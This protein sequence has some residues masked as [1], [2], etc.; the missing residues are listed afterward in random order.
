M[1]FSDNKIKEEF[2]SNG[3]AAIYS[4]FN[5]DKIQEIKNAIDRYIID[6][7]PTLPNHH[8]FYEDKLD[9]STIKNL[10]QMFNYDDYFKQLIDIATTISFLIAPFCAIANHLVIHSDDIP[11]SIRP[12]NWL[13]ILS[14]LGIIFLILFSIVFILSI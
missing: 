3:Y 6:I 8:V 10:Q 2:N 5:N 7:V 9:K 11:L 1:N 12:P 14:I 13:R 4:F